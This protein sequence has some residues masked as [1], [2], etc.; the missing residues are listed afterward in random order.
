MTGACTSNRMAYG[1]YADCSPKTLFQSVS[2]SLC[3]P[4]PASREH[5]AK[6]VCCLTVA[7]IINLVRPQAT[8]RAVPVSRTVPL[9]GSHI[10]VL[11][12]ANES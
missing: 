6:D 8:S 12:P 3:R 10:I 7:I 9:T 11:P 1:A 4:I 5:Y 2:P